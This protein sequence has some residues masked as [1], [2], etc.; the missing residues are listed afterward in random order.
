MVREI[1]KAPKKD[2]LKRFSKDFGKA[3]QELRK[4]NDGM[5]LRGLAERIEKSATYVSEVER[6]ITIPPPE[7][8]IRKIAK[9][10]HADAEEL[11]AL[12]GR[13]PQEAEEILRKRPM[14]MMAALR[15]VDGLSKK[16]LA[17]LLGKDE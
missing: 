14:E 8:V 10:L 15:T 5:S 9:V 12:S 7:E 1:P 17:E 11:I 4:K 2:V 3:I 16:K 6:G 13:I